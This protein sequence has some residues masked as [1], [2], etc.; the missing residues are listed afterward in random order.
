MMENPRSGKE[1]I[2]KDIWNLFRLNKEQNDT[3]MKDIRNFL[4]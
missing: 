2:I 4:D 3:P 1:N